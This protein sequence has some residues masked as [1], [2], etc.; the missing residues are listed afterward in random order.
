MDNP[1]IALVIGWDNEQSVQL[2]GL[3][4]VPVSAE[5]D[6][7]LERYYEVFPDGK[8]RN[9]NWA[10][11]AYLVVDPKWIRYSDFNIPEIKEVTY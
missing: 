5:L 10:D 11:I 3:A 1:A 4:R 7:L 2:E 9:K 8:D 6:Y